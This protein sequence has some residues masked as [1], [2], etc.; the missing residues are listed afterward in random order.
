MDKREL[1]KA[2]VEEI[3]ALH[4]WHKIPVGLYRGEE[5]ST[6]GIVSHCNGASAT[7]RYGMPEDLRGRTVLDIGSWDGGFSFEAERRGAARVLAADMVVSDPARMEFASWGENRGFLL[8]HRLLESRVEFIESSVND[9]PDKLN[10][11][12]FDLV[13]F[14]GVLYH[15]LDPL[16]ALRSVQRV[17]K[18]TALIETAVVPGEDLRLELRNGYDGDKTNRWYPTIPCVIEMLEVVGFYKVE[19]I[20]NYEGLRASFTASV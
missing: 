18:E 5:Y 10:G 2:D 9:L 4:W 14:Y 1:T 16:S 3:E 13:L 7:E 6:P 11:E 20:Y 12:R 19:M 15:V 17:T 8:A